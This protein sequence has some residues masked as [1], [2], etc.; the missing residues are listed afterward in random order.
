[1]PAMLGL[2][3]AAQTRTRDALPPLRLGV[4][5]SERLP[6]VRACIAP[7]SI[8]EAR[9][10]VGDATVISHAL[11]PAALEAIA[12]VLVALGRIALEHPEIAAVDVNPMIVD[13]NGA[14]AVDALVVGS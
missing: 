4:Q 6:G 3:G 10:L 9:R 2:R 11:S 13:Q 1:M 12:G 7:I 8:E 14:V 5:N